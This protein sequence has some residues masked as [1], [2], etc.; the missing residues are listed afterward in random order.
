MKKAVI[1]DTDP[2]IDDAVALGIGL[3]SDQ[4][5][6][7]LI[8]TVAGNVGIHYV[9][10]NMLKLLTFW[11]MNIPVAQGA[12]GPLL[13]EVK[14]ASDVHGVTGMAGYEFPAPNREYL[15]EETAVEAMHRTLMASGE[16]MTIIAIGPL[17]NIALLLKTYPEVK[18]RIEELVLMGG[19]LGRGNF[20][21][22]SE[23]NIAIDP[24]AAKIVFESGLS[25][26]V[27]PLDVG[28]KALVYPE[29]SEKI[30]DMNQTGDMMYHLFK[31]YRGGS[32]GTGLKMYDSCALAYVLSPEM[33]DIKETFVAVETAGEYTAGATII[34]LNN[35]LGKDKNCR[36][37]VDVDEDK[38]KDWFLQAISQCK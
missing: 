28:L 9:T 27:A 8:T 23:F 17:T 5:D 13:R 36:V 11:D 32:F 6:V 4:L 16:K 38:F 15:L 29:D 1:I 25:I 21:I 24:E 37:C 2:G 35:K 30:K 3:F 18:E 26:A 19:A 7:K 12:D 22:L 20:G 34:D 14:D 10:E 31:K 33:F